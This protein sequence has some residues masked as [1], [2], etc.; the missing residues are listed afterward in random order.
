M[1]RHADAAHAFG[2]ATVLNP[3]HTEARRFLGEECVQVDILKTAKQIKYCYA[4][5]N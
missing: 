2:N 3:N 4:K 5:L 1:Q